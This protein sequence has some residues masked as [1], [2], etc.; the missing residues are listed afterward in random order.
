M[1]AAFSCKVT[2]DPKSATPAAGGVETLLI[3]VQVQ[4]EVDDA[5]LVFEDILDGQRSKE[6]RAVVSSTSCTSCILIKF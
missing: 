3:A 6:L 2:V 1:P 4:Y 5:L